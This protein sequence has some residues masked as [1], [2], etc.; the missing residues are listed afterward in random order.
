MQSHPIKNGTLLICIDRFLP[1][2]SANTPDK[3]DPI[4]LVTAPKLAIIEKDQIYHFYRSHE[5]YL[6]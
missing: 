2:Y 6:A 3:I 5:F 4:G 1:K